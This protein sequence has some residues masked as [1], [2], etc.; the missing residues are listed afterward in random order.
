MSEVSTPTNSNAVSENDIEIVRTNDN[1]NNAPD[2]MPKEE[3]KPRIESVSP[4][5]SKI[6]DLLRPSGISNSLPN[7]TLNDNKEISNEEESNQE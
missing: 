6:D 1:E 2:V 5:G 4:F 7:N 3:V